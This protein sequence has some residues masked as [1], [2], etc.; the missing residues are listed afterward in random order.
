MITCPHCGKEFDE[1][2]KP[3]GKWYF[4]N[5][6]VIIALLCAGPLALPLIWFNPNYTK[7]T[8]WVA[9]I[10]II[11]ATVFIIVLSVKLIAILIE[12]FKNITQLISFDFSNHSGIIGCL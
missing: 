9:T 2:N 10:I 1:R 6:W 12:Q 7:I 5:Y 4:S 8:K 3:K 11:I